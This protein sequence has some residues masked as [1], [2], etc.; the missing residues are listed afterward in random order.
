MLESSI[1]KVVQSLHASADGAGLAVVLNKE[2]ESEPGVFAKYQS[3][4]L[5]LSPVSDYW[6]IMVCPEYLEAETVGV[7]TCALPIW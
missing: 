1:E 5:V 7:Q 3:L 6:I 2:L 4:S